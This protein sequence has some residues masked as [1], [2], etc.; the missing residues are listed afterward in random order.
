VLTYELL[1]GAS[2]FTIEGDKNT[3]QDIS[4]RIINADPM[5]PE[6]L[7]PEVKDFILKLLIKDPRKRLGKSIDNGFRGVIP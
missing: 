5:M 1:T 4:K 7:S 6:M 2:P 3:Q